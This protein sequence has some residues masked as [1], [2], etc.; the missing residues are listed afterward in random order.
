MATKWS[1]VF[2][3]GGRIILAIIIAVTIGAALKANRY[4]Y[5]DN[6]TPWLLGIFAGILCFV[7]LQVLAK[8]KG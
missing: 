3:T 6:V 5:K 8:G 7:L 4:F 1:E 2:I